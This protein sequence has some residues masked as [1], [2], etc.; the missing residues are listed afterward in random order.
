LLPAA[1]LAV[2]RD[3]HRGYLL[4]KVDGLPASN[5]QMAAPVA[6][7]VC[8]A[9][10]I[11]LAF[12]AILIA[13]SRSVRSHD[14]SDLFCQLTPTSQDA[15]IFH[16][17]LAPESFSENLKLAARSFDHWRYIHEKPGAHS[18]PE[19]F[20]EWLHRA[21]DEVAESHVRSFLGRASGA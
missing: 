19:L 13:E 3:F 8:L 21:A 2:S 5:G 9:F 12:K 16:S 7:V 17:G 20:L 10:A 6:S 14:L 4:C 18:A 11:E 15:I 1:A